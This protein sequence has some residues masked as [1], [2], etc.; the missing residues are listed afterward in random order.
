MDPKRWVIFTLEFN[1]SLSRSYN[2]TIYSMEDLHSIMI[3]KNIMRIIVAN[4]RLYTKFSKKKKFKLSCHVSKFLIRI[5]IR[6][7]I[8]FLLSSP[9]KKRKKTKISKIRYQFSFN[10]ILPRNGKY[11]QR[12]ETSNNES[13]WW[14]TDIQKGKTISPIYL[15]HQIYWKR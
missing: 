14:R 11:S 8:Y 5:A 1:R 9:Q 12:P 2:R 15:A 7:A 3:P 10:R 4:K 13:A 6:I